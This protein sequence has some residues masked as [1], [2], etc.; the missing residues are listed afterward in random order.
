MHVIEECIYEPTEG[1]ARIDR[2]PTDW[3][4]L[5]SARTDSYALAVRIA[6]ALSQANI[7]LWEVNR[8]GLIRRVSPSFCVRWRT[9]AETSRETSTETSSD[10]PGAAGAA[11]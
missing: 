11:E 9:E 6:E 10:L 7:G 8:D 5:R 4:V 3:K 2:G 1:G